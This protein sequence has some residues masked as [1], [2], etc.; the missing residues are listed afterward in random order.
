MNFALGQLARFALR[1][2]LDQIHS[3]DAL[4]NAQLSVD[5]PIALIAVKGTI[6]F[7]HNPSPTV[8]AARKE[9]RGKLPPYGLPISLERAALIRIILSPQ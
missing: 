5:R 7:Q 9:R 4:E 2:S 1:P 8:L 6:S 3:T